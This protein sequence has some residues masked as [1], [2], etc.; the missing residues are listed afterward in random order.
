M[1]DI[2]IAKHFCPRDLLAQTCIELFLAWVV[3]KNAP[4]GLK[5]SPSA[6]WAKMKESIHRAAGKSKTLKPP[7]HNEA[8]NQ[9][10]S[11]EKAKSVAGTWH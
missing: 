7:S 5:Q 4:L 2:D 10:P 6:G 1:I 11:G 8:A 9:R 3:N